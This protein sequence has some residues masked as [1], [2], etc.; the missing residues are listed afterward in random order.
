MIDK[1]DTS[2]GTEYTL[3]EEEVDY[4]SDGTSNR[5]VF[6]NTVLVPNSTGSSTQSKPSLAVLGMEEALHAA[7]TG[8]QLCDAISDPSITYHNLKVTSGVVDAPDAVQGADFCSGKDPCQIDTTDISFDQVIWSGDQ[9][10]KVNCQYTFSDQ[11]PFLA[12]QLKQCIT[13]VVLEQNQHVL[14]DQCAEVVDFQYGTG[15]TN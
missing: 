14:V 15:T 10:Q 2:D 3:A 13:S 5:S 11:V 6:E 9:G 8:P 4:N 7:S 12:S 1:T